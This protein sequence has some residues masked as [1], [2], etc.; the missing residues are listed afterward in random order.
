MIRI[1]CNEQNT[2]FISIANAT[3]TILNLSGNAYVEVDFVS[4]NDIRLVNNSTRNV[5]K[6][7]D[8]LSFPTLESIMPFTK[9]NYPYECNEDGEIALGNILICEAVARRQAQEY[10][11]S[12]ERERSYLFTHGLLH[13]LGYDHVEESDKVV[14]R[15]MEEKVLSSLGITRGE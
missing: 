6:V 1:D 5:D 2:E 14:M 15:K 10:G 7:T 8:V 9:E 4:E 12:V 3:F 13:L 11:Q